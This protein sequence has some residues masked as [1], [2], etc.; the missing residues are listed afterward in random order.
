[1]YVL[2]TDLDGTFLES[3][4]RQNDALYDFLNKHPNFLLI[5]VTGRN[6]ELVLPIIDDMVIPNPDYFIGDVGATVID[7]KTLEPVQPLL[8]KISNRWRKTLEAIKDVEELSSLEVQDQP[9]ERRMSFYIHPD[10]KPD[11][12]IKKLQA[13]DCDVLYSNDIYLDIL[14]T[15]VN[16]GS[17]LRDLIDQLGIQH[18]HVLVAGDTMNDLSMYEAGYKGVVLQNS[19]QPLKDAAQ[20]MKN[21]YFS[22]ETGTDGILE[23]LQHFKM[24]S[25]SQIS[26]VKT[27]YGKADLVMVYH[28][29]PYSEVFEDGQMTREKH[30]SPNGIVPTLL[31]FF[32]ESQNGSWVAWS[33]SE[34]R[35]PDKFEEHVYVDREKYENLQ[36]CRIPLTDEDVRIFYEVFSKEAFWLLLHSFHEKV[37]FNHDHWDHFVEINRIFAEKVAQEAAKGAIVWVHDYNLW[38]VPAF[39]RQMRPDVKIAFFH[40]T[41][42]PS[43]DIFN[44]IPW[45]RE[46]INSLLKCDYVGFHIPQYV[47]NF[48]NVVRSNYRTTINSEKNSAPYF[49]TYGC[50]IGADSYVTSLST[51]LDTV[52]MG[53]HPVGINCAYIK[54]LVKSDRVQKLYKQIKDEIGDKKCI[55]SIER[56]D[57]TKG[58]VE[59]LIGYQK[60]L[61]DHPDMH[62][63]VNLIMVCT[64]PAKGMKIYEQVSQ[65]VAYH[66][67]LINGKFGTYNWSPINFVNRM[68]PFEDVI[69]Y[70]MAADV[71]WVTPLRDGLN[72]VC[73][74][75]V[76]AKKASGELGSLVLSEFAGA[77]TELHGAFLVNPYDVHAMSETLYTALKATEGDKRSRM[78]R[79]ASTVETYDVN[80]WG[81]DFL[82]NVKNIPS[83]E[84]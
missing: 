48:T 81:E 59:K 23:A 33:K 51:D 39:L 66:V 13:L 27:Q 73:K 71:G 52:H 43:A 15:G 5:F 6:T 70:Y 72:L 21:V 64:P 12:I 76:M 22:K 75:Y 35:T 37:V 16:K 68:I 40:H 31:G 4:D 26:T 14:P 84:H 54:E 56:T 44:M 28:R 80:A 38:M 17:T 3:K 50:A 2:A 36:V 69:A 55:L 82:N 8:H 57:Y 74:E 19:E 9:Q 53:A 25:K 45:R 7:G 58:P 46:I 30:A 42:F 41:P 65:D 24:A 63:E 18:D 1:M 83:E 34:S 79:M 47:E 78:N 10:N 32:S 61:E 20:D 29:L 67:G 49:K 11:K 62:E 60:F 77:A